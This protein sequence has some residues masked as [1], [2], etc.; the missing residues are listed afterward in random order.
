MLKIPKNVSKCFLFH[1]SGSNVHSCFIKLS[2]RIRDAD[3]I[4]IEKDKGRGKSS[5]LIA[6]NKRMVLAD[7]E[8]VCSGHFINIPMEEIT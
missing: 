8:C 3:S 2:L 4:Y 7:M 5:P 1:F 6:I